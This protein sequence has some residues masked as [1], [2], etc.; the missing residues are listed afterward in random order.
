MKRDYPP[1]VEVNSLKRYWHVRGKEGEEAKKD[2][3][4]GEGQT[5][6]APYCLHCQN[7]ENQGHHPDMVWCYYVPPPYRNLVRDQ[8][9]VAGDTKGQKRSAGIIPWKCPRRDLLGCSSEDKRPGQ[10]TGDKHKIVAVFGEDEPAEAQLEKIENSNPDCSKGAHR[11]YC[12]RC[13]A[14]LSI[15]CANSWLS[16]S[17]LLIICLDVIHF[18]EER[19]K[20]P[21]SQLGV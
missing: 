14:E 9:E 4:N 8:A 3:G 2:A 16:H 6:R 21:G 12:S 5:Y 10:Q 13:T 19:S 17:T 1:K 15:Y 11:D 7:D 20:R 18:A